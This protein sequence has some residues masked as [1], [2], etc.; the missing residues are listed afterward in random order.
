MEADDPAHRWGPDE[1]AL[2]EAAAEQAAIVLENARLIEE[3]ENALAESRRLAAR[4]QT[5]NVIAGKVRG[6]P[7]VDSILATALV[8]LGRTLGANRG[9]VRLG[10]PK[11]D[12]K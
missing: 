11:G 8:E 10:A 5:V 3:A 4:E 7:N 2:I 6:A 9:S 12:S 1:V